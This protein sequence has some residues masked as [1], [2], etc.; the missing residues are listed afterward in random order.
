M[1]NTVLL[2]IL[3]LLIFS[4]KKDDN[5]Q[6][7]IDD[8][9]IRDYLSVNNIDATKHESGLYYLITQEGTGVH[10]TIHSKVTLKYKG[11]FKD[12]SVFDESGNSSITYHLSGFI[13]GWQ[14]G[15]PLL[16]T[17]GKGTLFVPS[18]LGYGPSGKGAIP[19]NTVI[20]FDV[21]L[22]EVE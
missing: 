17:G 3:T 1:R 2:L 20:F 15:I 21:E 4:C 19:G 16:K 14:I 10:P 22:I 13:T 6:V 5:S 18:N 11:Y 7:E 12:G 9:I 8:E